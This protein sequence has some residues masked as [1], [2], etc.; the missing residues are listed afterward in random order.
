MRL[1][2]FFWT[3]HFTFN[4]ASLASHSCTTSTLLNKD[5]Q[6]SEI[7]DRVPFQID[8]YIYLSI[9]KMRAIDKI[10]GKNNTNPVNNL[11]NIVGFFASFSSH[12]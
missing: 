7:W 12:Q 5:M 3:K 6:F 1:V 4:L 10:N 8:E 2:I 11:S 9:N